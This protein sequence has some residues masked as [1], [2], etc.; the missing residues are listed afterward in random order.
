VWP[1]EHP[2]ELTVA[3]AACVAATSL[4]VVGL[5]ARA[6]LLS[7]AGRWH[8]VSAPVSAGAPES[9]FMSFHA[10]RETGLRRLFNG[11][12][13]LTLAIAGR[14]GRVTFEIWVR[15]GDE[16]LVHALARAAFPGA[17]TRP[18]AEIDGCTGRVVG[19]RGRLARGNE[20][21]LRTRFEAEPLATLSSTLAQ[22]GQEERVA[23][24]IALRPKSP[25]WSE[26]VSARSES[27]VLAAR[28]GRSRFRW[29][30]GP[31]ETADA[32]H[33]AIGEK[34]TTPAFDCAIR[35]V[36][37]SDEPARCASRIRAAAAALGPY[38][39][40]NWLEFSR[41]RAMRA[42]RN[43]ARRFPLMGTVV[44]SAREL[45]ALWHVPT[46]PVARFEPVESPKLAAPVG[47]DRGGR[48]LGRTSW[49][50]EDLP[51]RLSIADSRHHLHVLGPTG[52]GKTTALLGL[53]SGDIAAGRGVGVLD[54]K[55]DLIRGILER[56]P[57]ERRDDVI[58]ISPDDENTSVGIN[59]LE[60]VPGDDRDLIAENTLTIFKRIYADS[61]GMRTDD[62]L[63]A[64]VLTLLQQPN[65]TLAHIPL[66]LT[67]A[68]VRGR[69]IAGAQETLGLDSFWRWYERLA[70][71]QR[72][73]AIG[74]VLNKLRDF[75]VRPR[76]RRV[77]CQPR[78]TVDLREIV[79]G[80]KILLADL[81]VG[82][83]GETASALLGSFLVAKL[84]QAVLARAATPEDERR[85]FFL[86]IDEFQ[87]F[88]GMR[89]PFG[90][91]L[92]EARSLR[93]CLTIANQHLG[94]LPRELR[95]AVISNARSRAVFQCGPYDAR[96]L[97]AEFAPL[98]A[99][100]LMSLPRFEM[101][102]RLSIDGRTSAPFT[103]RTLAPPLAREAASV[104]EVRAA[105]A[106]RYGRPAAE[107]D[108]ELRALLGTEPKSGRAKR[109]R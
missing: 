18:L 74:P 34:L 36:A 88:L 57:R 40:A 47:V 87:R 75:L 8:T 25:R 80:G 27:R 81:S 48:L 29:R 24:E 96:A 43:D 90:D 11:Q 5:C 22:L 28:S 85:D 20:L 105:S 71:Y 76:L 58:L 9:F 86:F 83:W 69:T 91:A 106:Q 37:R 93:L 55:G 23:V 26:R 33:G 15:Q 59:P 12:P 46:A 10:L 49:A 16:A 94:Q 21:P 14:P 84:W 51:V 65:A 56:L 103:M 60:V 67:D 13:W 78:S 19:A 70:E 41:P 54:P 38:A 32:R 95:D 61:W 79:E 72:L 63:K 42:E 50:G 89:G 62:I 99:G 30:R 68:D 92:A 17:E 109:R 39:G 1:I 45:A 102:V 82:R 2:F 64:T 104:A 31:R 108:A 97:A 107:L 98:D 35:V 73:E 52:T 3:A 101:A 53:A 44:L 4:A 66:L 6:A 7:S 77:L 100:A